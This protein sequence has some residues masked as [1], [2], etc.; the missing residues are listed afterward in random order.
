MQWYYFIIIESIQSIL[1]E[2]QLFSLLYNIY[3]KY[4]NEEII[5]DILY[6]IKNIIKNDNISIESFY[7]SKL[8]TIFENN[9]CDKE[10]VKSI[11]NIIY[12]KSIIKY[13]LD[14]QI[15]NKIQR[16]IK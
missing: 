1:V 14:E 13:F 8:Y 9:L 6:I 11:F 7:Q 12:V 16:I 15:Y 2:N 10:L 4:S 3:N 5:R